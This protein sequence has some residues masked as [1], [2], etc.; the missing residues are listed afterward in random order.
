MK[1]KS[2]TSD[3]NMLFAAG[4]LDRGVIVNVNDKAAEDFLKNVDVDE[5]F[6]VNAEA[7]AE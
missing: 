2:N 3:N 4:L 5:L 6:S 1:L 7:E